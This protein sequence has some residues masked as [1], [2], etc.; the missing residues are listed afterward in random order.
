METSFERYKGP[1]LDRISDK[2]PYGMLVL[3]TF[4]RQVRFVPSAR[5]LF[6][7]QS[8]VECV[9]AQASVVYWIHWVENSSPF[10]HLLGLEI[11]RKL[12]FQY[13]NTYRDIADEI[14]RRELEGRLVA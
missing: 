5:L 4:S 13:P 11:C 12:K 10:G 8:P 3:L 7:P 14:D 9:A 6:Y 2:P 1:C